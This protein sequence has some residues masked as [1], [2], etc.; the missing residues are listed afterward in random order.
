VD[1]PAAEL[2][3]DRLRL[4][5][6]VPSDLARMHAILSDLRATAY[7]STPPHESL[8]QSEAFLAGMIGGAPPEAEEFVVEHEDVLI[9][10]VGLWRFPEIGFIFDPAW[11]GRGFATEAARAVLDRAF[12][13]HRLPAVEAD[14]DPRNAASLR[15]LERIGFR[16]TGRAERTLLVDGVW[17]DSVYLRLD[18]SRWDTGRP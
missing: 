16:E 14:V 13:V 12:A 10:K 5:P 17:C 1:T 3:T 11:W 6:P 2:R 9:G 4:R 15:L 7:W 8:D 18:A